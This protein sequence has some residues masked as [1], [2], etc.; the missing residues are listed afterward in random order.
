LVSLFDRRRQ[1]DFSYY[2]VCPEGTAENPRIRVFMD[3]LE[4]I[5]QRDQSAL[6]GIGP[7]GGLS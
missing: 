4:Q 5:A 6:I 7:A 1:A 3:W 2:V